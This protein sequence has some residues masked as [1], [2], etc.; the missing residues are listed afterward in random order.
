MINFQNKISK[1]T[2]ENLKE[3]YK[4]VYTCDKCKLKYGSDKEEKTTHICPI[5]EQK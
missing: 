4:Y 3:I 1:E 2:T 5:C